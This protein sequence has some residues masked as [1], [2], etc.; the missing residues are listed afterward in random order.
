[1]NVR[2]GSQGLLHQM[3]RTLLDAGAAFVGCA[4]L[5]VLDDGLRE[6]FPR[7]VSIAIAFRP[8]VVGRWMADPT[9]GLAAEWE[10]TSAL[11]KRVAEVCVRFLVEHGHR[12]TAVPGSLS[13][14]DERTLTARLPHKTVATLAGVGWIGTCAVLVTE[15]FGSALRLVSVLTDAGLPTAVPTTDPRCGDCDAC[16]R[17]CPAGAIRGKAWGVGVARDEM[18][19]AFACERFNADLAE[20][21]ES[22]HSH[23]LACIAA[24]PWTR[25]YV[26]RA[27]DGAAN[28][29][30]LGR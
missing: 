13:A 1:M 11:R 25:G 18:L 15:G 30:D 7:G 17:A 22:A 2:A 28:R 6:G 16:V 3:E 23:C 5:T 9:V 14:P 4:D 10:R 20:V 21:R 27:A 26:E 29:P 12:A 24:C 19:D 8:E